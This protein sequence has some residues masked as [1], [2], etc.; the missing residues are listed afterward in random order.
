M[1]FGKSFRPLDGE[2]FSKLCVCRNHL[3]WFFHC[4]R[5]LDG[6]SFSKRSGLRHSQ[7]VIKTS[8]RPLDGESFSKPRFDPDFEKHNI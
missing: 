7:I 8:F 4:F 2:S 5:P 6:E 1:S 3:T